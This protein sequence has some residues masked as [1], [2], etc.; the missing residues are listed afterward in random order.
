MSTMIARGR[1]ARCDLHHV[2]PWLRLPGEAAR[3]VNSAENNARFREIG[4]INAPVAPGA[5]L[6]RNFMLMRF[7]LALTRF[8]AAE[9]DCE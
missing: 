5:V 7:A 2:I 6:I 3:C 4:E 9:Q 8:L 1:E